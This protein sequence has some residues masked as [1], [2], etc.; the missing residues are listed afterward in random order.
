MPLFCTQIVY[1]SWCIFC[2][3]W[4]W[5]WW[6]FVVSF[7][8]R[9]YPPVLS[10]FSFSQIHIFF[11]MV[12]SGPHTVPRLTVFLTTIRPIWLIDPI[13]VPAALKL[14]L[15]SSSLLAMCFFVYVCLSLLLEICEFWPGIW[16][17]VLVYSLVVFSFF[18]H[19]LIRD[20]PT[21]T[22]RFCVC[23][24]VRRSSAP[25]PNTS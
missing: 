9:I 4:W 18:P 8:G 1:V 15:N 13:A 10:F 2:F 23:V 17:L 25:P 12:V 6:Q 16:R 3:C 14:F 24:F 5:W 7:G 21:S 22:D 19:F 20:Y 11:V